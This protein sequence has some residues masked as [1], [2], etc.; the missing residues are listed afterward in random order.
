MKIFTCILFGLGFLVNEPAV[1]KEPLV[2]QDS[3]TVLDKLSKKAKSYSSIYAEYSMTIVDKGETVVNTTGK[4]SIKGDKFKLIMDDYHIY[5]DGESV[6][7][8]DTE[9]NECFIN[10]FEE[11]QEEQDITPSELFTIW[12][13]GFK[14][15]HKGSVEE[16]GKSLTKINLYPTDSSKEYHTIELLIDEGK[17]EMKKAII[18]GRDGQT[19]TYTVKTFTP[20]KNLEDKEFVFSTADHPGCECE[21]QRF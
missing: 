21:D 13:D 14:H 9:A 19:M 6:W 10:D 3:K 5:C 2:E 18:K 7:T 16:G 15:E 20:N 12:E 11:M 8:Y 17:M 4:A 1:E